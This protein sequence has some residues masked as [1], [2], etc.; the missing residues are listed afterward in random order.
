MHENIYNCKS[1][2]EMIC[3]MQIG[4]DI[5]L[6]IISWNE[7]TKKVNKVENV[8]YAQK[9]LSVKYAR[10]AKD[11]ENAWSTK[12]QCAYGEQTLWNIFLWFMC[13]KI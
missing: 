7:S 8:K 5:H 3:L 13:Q 10:N 11:A 12:M 1:D 9:K 4:F 6:Y 2:I